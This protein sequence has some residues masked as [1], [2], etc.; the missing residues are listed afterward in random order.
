MSK[1]EGVKKMNNDYSFSGTSD[2]S[3]KYLSSPRE[4][5]GP[6]QEQTL[7]FASNALPRHQAAIGT[8]KE[9]SKDTGGHVT[10]PDEF[11]NLPALQGKSG[12]YVFLFEFV[13]FLDEI[14]DYNQIKSEYDELSLA[15]IEGA[16]SFLQKVAQINARGIDIDY[17][18][19]LM[20]FQDEA[21]VEEL[22][23][24]LADKDAARVLN[25]SE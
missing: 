15:Q 25:F 6:K 1:N 9:L 12:D 2:S 18:E 20:I 17:L 13:E 10:F 24:S 23:K 21:F 5:T 22:R 8:L 11:Y 19:D 4:S 16:I 3:S 14:I 7:L